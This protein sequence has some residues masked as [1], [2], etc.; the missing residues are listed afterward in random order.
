[1]LLLSCARALSFYR[2][3]VT[4][5][6]ATASEQLF[7]LAEALLRKRFR[8]MTNGAD[9]EAAAAEARQARSEEREREQEERQREESTSPLSTSPCSAEKSA[10]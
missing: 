10:A 1:L 8:N 7:E 4:L 9:A 3:P 2:S 6:V 5:S